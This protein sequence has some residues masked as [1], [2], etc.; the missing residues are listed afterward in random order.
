MFRKTKALLRSHAIKWRLLSLGIILLIPFI[1]NNCWKN[2]FDLQNIS[3]PDT[4]NPDVC[5]PLIHSRMSMKD[6]LNDWDHNNL[7]VEDATHFLYLVYWNKVF[8]RSAGEMLAIPDQ[9]VSSTYTFSVAGGP[10]WG[11]VSAGPYTRTYAFTMPNTEILDR[12]ILN[13]NSGGIPGGNLA[14]YVTSP[15][16]NHNATINISIPSATLSG[17][18]FNRNIDYTAGVPLNETIDLSGYDIQFGAGNTIDIIYT[19][20]LHGSGGANLS[21]YVLDLNESFEILSFHAMYG[22]FKQSAFSLPNDTVY[23]IID[24]ENPKLHMWAYNSLGIPLDITLSNIRVHSD[25]NAPYDLMI[26]DGFPVP[27]YVN[28]P[29]LAQIGQV[30]T[31]NFTIDKTNSTTV[32][33][34]VNLAPKTIIVDIDGLTNPGGGPSSN[35]V[36]DT[37]RVQIDCQV[38]LPLHGRAWDFRLA[39]TLDF[40]FGED[41]DMDLIQYMMFRINTENGFPVD[42]IMQLYFADENDVILD[43]LLIPAQQTIT[44]APVG[45]G[46]DYR[47]TEP[48][49]ARVEAVIEQPRLGG[50]APTAKIIVLGKLNTYSNGT[51]IVKIY[52]DYY[53]DVRLGARAIFNVE[54]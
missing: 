36:I 52:S 42:G 51:Q 3:T 39:D 33:P 26:T 32:G 11:D 21:P 23:G 31:T 27:W 43:S 49:F 53:L 46:P 48:R 4:W 6:I 24:W 15:N 14:F 17:V 7:F 8:S 45:P 10:V 40:E 29:S 47:V 30:I 2:R 41:M 16:L 18:P 20:T 50:L 34:A 22:D 1:F 12:V 37:S 9:N 54:F 44:A 38:E 35:F 28:A 25:A 13:E 5:A 19:A